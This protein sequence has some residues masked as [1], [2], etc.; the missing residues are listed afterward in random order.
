MRESTFAWHTWAWA[1]L[2]SEKGKS[3]AYVYYYDHRTPQ[4]PNGAGHGPAADQGQVPRTKSAITVPSRSPA[5]SCRKWP[6][7]SMT[8]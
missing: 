4:Q 6:A 3:K 5:S 7:P 8:G 2:Q 1:M